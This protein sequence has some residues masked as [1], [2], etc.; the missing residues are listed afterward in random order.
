MLSQLGFGFG[1]YVPRRLVTVPELRARLD[2]IYRQTES[3]RKRYR[4][5]RLLW[6]RAAAGA[7][8]YQNWV[9]N[10]QQANA[11]SAWTSLAAGKTLIVDGAVC[12]PT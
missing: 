5:L 2:D 8:G 12:V 11:E 10:R 3:A 7:Q 1:P 9:A 4:T 6:D